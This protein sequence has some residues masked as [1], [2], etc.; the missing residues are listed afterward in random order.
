MIT[1]RRFLMI[2]AVAM[3]AKP[4]HA[5]VTRWRDIAFGADVTI[6]LRG[7]RRDAAHALRMVRRELAR[8]QSLFSLY[9]PDS[10]L[11][12]LN[13]SGRLDRPEPDFSDLLDLCGLCHGATGGRFDPT[14]QGLWQALASGADTGAAERA[15]GWNTVAHDSTKVRLGRGQALTFNGIAQG[16]ATDRIADALGRAGFSE[17]LVNIGEFR[18]GSG[19]WVLGIADPKFG[20]VDRRTLSNSAIATSSPRAVSIGPRG[21]SHIIDPLRG[22][23]TPKWSTVSVIADRAALADGL[24]TALCFAG[25]AEI[26]TIKRRTDAVREIVLVDFEGTVK[27]V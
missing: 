21:L 18:A 23:D 11:S 6:T 14:V 7:P 5:E 9:D 1:R 22:N 24:S 19:P 16:F 17:T 2:S 20:L 3:M 13:R 10:A 8:L 4:A 12:V 27:A 26:Q 15:I 25:L